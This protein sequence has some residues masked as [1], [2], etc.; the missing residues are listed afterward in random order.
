[1]TQR[2]GAEGAGNVPMEA[3][4]G[5]GEPEWVRTAALTTVTLTQE[6][7]APAIDDTELADWL[8]GAAVEAMAE[9]PPWPLEAAAAVVPVLEADRAR[10]ERLA[11]RQHAAG[12]PGR[13]AGDEVST[14]CHLMLQLV[15]PTGAAPIEDLVTYAHRTVCCL[16]PPAA[17]RA[18]LT[19]ATLPVPAQALSAFEALASE[20]QSSRGLRGD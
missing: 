20:W 4:D 13:E 15:F 8:A 12:V 19:A 10:A 11:A 7:G 14:W 5:V 3:G 18:S 9:G 1:M 2:M 16:A 6:L 17:W